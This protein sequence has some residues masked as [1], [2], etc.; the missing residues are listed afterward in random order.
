[1]TYAIIACR[2]FNIAQQVQDYC[3]R[4]TALLEY[5]EVGSTVG[6]RAKVVAFFKAMLAV[7]VDF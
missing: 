5:F 6:Q 4:V 3:I 1:M 7:G 2:K